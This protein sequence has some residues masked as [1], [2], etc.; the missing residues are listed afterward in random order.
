[1][2]GWRGHQRCKTSDDVF[3][4][5]VG[6]DDAAAWVADD[7]D[8]IGVVEF[9]QVHGG[10]DGLVQLVE[11]MAGARDEWV[12]A[13][14]DHAKAED[15][16]RNRVAPRVLVL[17]E[18]S[19]CRQRIREALRRA[20]IQPAGLGDFG[21]AQA[22]LTQFKSAQDL[23]RLLDRGD[24]PG[25]IGRGLGF[26]QQLPLAVYALPLDR[27]VRAILHSNMTACNACIRD[28]N[29]IWVIEHE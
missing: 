5:H 20:F 8:D 4:H 19:Q 6:G 24:E 23:E 1:M 21:Q 10:V 12:G 9:G 17:L 18:V 27:R 29:S 15:L 25:R 7:I 13:Q 11:L 2:K 14:V 28:A 22:A 26:L 16:G 3:Q